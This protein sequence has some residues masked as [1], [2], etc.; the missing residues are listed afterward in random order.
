M[1]ELKHAAKIH[2][3]E[4]RLTAKVCVKSTL[5]ANTI[6]VTVALMD[7]GFATHGA[8]MDQHLVQLVASL[9]ADKKTLVVTA[10]PTGAH[11]PPGPAYLCVVTNTGA[12]RFDHKPIVGTGASPPVDQAVIVK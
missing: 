3:I 2:R 4:N 1:T 6:N 8:H 9:S 7:L 12:P 11:Y 10:P 5:P